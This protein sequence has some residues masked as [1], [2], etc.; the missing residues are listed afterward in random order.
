M[1]AAAPVRPVK[2]TT[3][4]TRTP[5]VSRLPPP[6]AKAAIPVLAVRLVKVTPV[7]KSAG[8]TLTPGVQT[9]RSAAA[10]KSS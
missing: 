7:G 5:L 6:P 3:S 4:P 10:M 8:A 1:V 9:P 2:F